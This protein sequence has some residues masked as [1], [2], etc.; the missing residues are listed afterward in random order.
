M[1]VMWILASPTLIAILAPVT[2]ALGLNA[3]A[4]GLN[5]AFNHGAYAQPSGVTAAFGQ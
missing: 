1:P 4:S 5:A 3:A 2:L